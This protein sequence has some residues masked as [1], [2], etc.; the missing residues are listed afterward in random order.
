M[1]LEP[2]RIERRWDTRLRVNGP[3][4]SWRE[5]VGN[6]LRAAAMRLDGRWSL[7]VELRSSERLDVAEQKEVLAAGF[8]EWT[9]QLGVATRLAAVEQLMRAQR[10]DLFEQR[11]GVEP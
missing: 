7:A 10:P 4:A 5:R 8:D 2:V 9:R 6:W 3:A 1:R 11:E